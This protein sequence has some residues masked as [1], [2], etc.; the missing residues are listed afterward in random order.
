MIKTWLS[1]AA[2][3]GFALLAAMAPASADTTLVIGIAADPTGF[4]PEAVLNNTSGFVMATV[5]DSL[6]RYKAGTTEVA[7]GL[8]EKWDVSADG[9][10]YTFHLRKGVTFQD[11]TPFNAKTYIQGIDRLLNK[12]NPDSIFNTG[13]VEGMIDFTYE[14]VTSYRAVD[15]DTVEFKLKQP[16]AP[17]LA[18]LAM[19]WNGVISPAAV[20]KY[21]KDFRNHPV[22]SGP[23]AFKEWR[24]RDQIVLDANPN[25]WGGKPKVDHLVFKEYPDPQAALLALKRGDIQILGDVSAQSIAALRSDPN[26]QLVT[27]PGLAISGVGLPNEVAPFNDK[28]VRQALNYGIDRDAIDKALFQGLAVPMTGPL[29]E[30]Q[31]GFDPA[32]KGYGYDP[33]RAKKLLEE[34]GVKPGIKVEFLT[35]N[36][37][38]GYNP[39]GPDLATAIQ[40]YLQKIGVEADVRKVDM[41]ANLATI[42]SGKYQ[43]IFMVGWT[44]DNGDPDN[45]VGELFNSKNIPVG[46][47]AHYRNP[48]ADALLDQAVKESDPQKRLALYS[49]IQQMILD[50]A[51]WI[52]V[53]SVLQV[54]AI[55]KEVKGY[56]LNPTQM[57]FD[58][59]NVS[60][61]R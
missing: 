52:F 50:D 49:K 43:G 24:Q 42:R 61:E 12:Q 16:S 17:L 22:G 34:A 33:D 29:P 55:R 20:T 60:L 18:S 26:I 59:Q 44:G 13:P 4:D 11:G 5:Y 19:V 8:A 7:P 57:F 3:F 31:W 27:Q 25:Y 21:G 54:R 41:G 30:S 15:D 56:M 1:S 48:Q 36:S 39:A 47:T 38:R 9:L 28:R 46:N 58:M 23:F 10:T 40:G 14:D 45:F 6:V 32:L 51:P 35:Y 53:N 2:V 37:P